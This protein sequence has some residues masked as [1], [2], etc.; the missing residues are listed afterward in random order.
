MRTGASGGNKKSSKSDQPKRR[1]YNV[2]C[3][4]HKRRLRELERHI[5]KHPIAHPFFAVL[6][7]VAKGK[8]KRKRKK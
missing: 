7:F 5:D 3:R 4:G 2:E 6:A 8:P 1:R